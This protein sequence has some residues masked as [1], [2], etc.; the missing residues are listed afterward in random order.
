[1]SDS[2]ETR[3]NAVGVCVYACLDAWMHAGLDRLQLTVAATSVRAWGIPW[4][5]RVVRT[6]GKPNNAYGQVQA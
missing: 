3:Y 4:W 1:M 2:R 6:R 5:A